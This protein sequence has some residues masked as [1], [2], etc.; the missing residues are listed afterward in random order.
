M[1]TTL[2]ILGACLVVP[3]VYVAVQYN[4]LVGLRNYIRN[5]WSNIDT[6]LKRRYDLIPALV[7]T[8]KGYTAHEAGVLERVTQMR[9]RCVASRGRPAEQAADERQLVHE[10]QQLL[11]VAENYPNLKADAQFAA[12]HKELVN[13]EDRI[14]AARRFFNGNV[15]DYR[16]KRESFPSNLVAALFNFGPEEYFSVEPSVREVPNVEF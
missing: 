8:V 14:Q 5:S 7:E 16:V 15:R 13:T 4:Q 6:E 3:L 11:A 10:L 2:I 12:L 9:A 1:E